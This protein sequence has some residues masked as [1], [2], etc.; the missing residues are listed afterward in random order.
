VHGGKKAEPGKYHALRTEY[1]GFFYD[2]K[3]EAQTAMSLDWSLKANEIKGWTRQFP[4]EIRSPG[5]KAHPP[6]QGGVQDR[7]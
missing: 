3:F 2:S 4:I 5:G 6:A 7:A 1:G